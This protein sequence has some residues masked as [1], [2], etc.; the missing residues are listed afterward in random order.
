MP[1]ECKARGRRERSF[2]ASF[3]QPFHFLSSRTVHVSTRPRLGAPSTVAAR[4]QPSGNPAS[5]PELAAVRRLSERHTNH[6]LFC[7]KRL[8]RF[9]RPGP[10]AGCGGCV[11]YLQPRRAVAVGTAM[12]EG[13]LARHSNSRTGIRRTWMGPPPDL[14]PFLTMKPI[15]TS[16]HCTRYDGNC[17]RVEAAARTMRGAI[18]A[19]ASGLSRQGKVGLPNDDGVA[20]ANTPSSTSQ[21][22][23]PDDRYHRFERAP[24]L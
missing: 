23:G 19:R 7:G 11:A 13:M 1:N 8:F 6:L 2:R 21:S 24:K 20:N 5:P 15:L 9:Q 10:A 16:L 3:Q 18:L 22:H 4:H 17:R 12:S 14:P